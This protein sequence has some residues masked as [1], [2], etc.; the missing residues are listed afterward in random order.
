M[1]LPK[2]VSIVQIWPLFLV[3]EVLLEVILTS[4]VPLSKGAFF[5]GLSLKATDII[6]YTLTIYALNL[7][8]IELCMT[9]KP[10]I[11]TRFGLNQ[12]TKTTLDMSLVHTE[13][14]SLNSPSIDNPSQRIQEDIKLS[15]MN[16]LTVKTEY[17]ISGLIV[18]YLIIYN[19]SSYVL[20]L[21]SLTYSLVS[22]GIALFFQPRMLKTEKEVQMQEAGFRKG[23]DNAIY[24]QLGACYEAIIAAA[25]VRLGYGI[26]SRLQS[27]IMLTLPYLVLL[28]QYVNSQL[29][30][31][32]LMTTATTF[33]L[34]VV[35]MTILINQFPNLVTA[36]ASQERVDELKRYWG[37]K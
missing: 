21:G 25:R 26:F 29:T 9:F 16:G 30:L 36:K 19:Y 5:N 2:L 32:Q 11:I 27:I 14:N 3:I 13:T 34:L 18:L 33:D 6:L 15:I 31:G 10:Y 20:I 35:N 8:S 17:A 28:P 1:K 23:L 7:L 22:I 12:R 4:V 37:D 24:S